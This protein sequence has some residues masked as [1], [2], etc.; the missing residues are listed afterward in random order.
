[1]K[2]ID[3]KYRGKRGKGKEGKRKLGRNRLKKKIL[4]QL[5]NLVRNE[6]ILHL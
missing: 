2:D 6:K 5:K 1:M 4:K 3:L